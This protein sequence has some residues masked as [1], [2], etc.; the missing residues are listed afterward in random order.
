MGFIR[1]PKDVDFVV[2]SKPWTEAELLEFR[3]LMKKLREA[4]KA[5]MQ[6]VQPKRTSKKLA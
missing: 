4:D 3:A 2:E 6:R 1:E 5:K